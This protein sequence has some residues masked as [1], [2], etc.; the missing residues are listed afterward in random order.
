MKG[1]SL[2]PEARADLREAVSYLSARNFSA[3]EALAQS[4]ISAFHLIT[5]HPDIAPRRTDLSKHDIR[6]WVVHPFLLVYRVKEG[7]PEF[8]AILHASQD[9]AHLLAGRLPAAATASEDIHD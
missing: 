4:I 5:D 9:V 3:G 7:S 2:T 1:Y 6:F 8:I